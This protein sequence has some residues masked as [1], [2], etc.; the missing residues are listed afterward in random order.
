MLATSTSP[1]PSPL[2]P[3]FA[4]PASPTKAM[5]A[6]RFPDVANIFIR[7]NRVK[8]KATALHSTSGD[9]P[10]T[11]PSIQEVSER[12]VPLAIEERFVCRDGVDAAKLLRA[13]RSSVYEKAESIGASV[14]VDEQWTC[15]IAGP[16]KDNTY[17]V[18]IRYSA[19]AARSSSSDPQKP[20]SLE[21]A[22]G[23]PGLMTVLAREQ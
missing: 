23:V 15:S 18:V 11:H 16:R 13:V 17:R 6:L 19:S 14:L 20:V 2:S 8:A 7:L 22:K 9:Q 4:V 12:K 5:P 1:P 21:Q 3:R 10:L